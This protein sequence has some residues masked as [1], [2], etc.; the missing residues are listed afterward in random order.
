M[1]IYCKL[2]QMLYNCCFL[3]GIGKTTFIRVDMD[4]YRFWSSWSWGYI[5]GKNFCKILPLPYPLPKGWEIKGFWPGY[6][7]KLFSV[8]NGLVNT[9]EASVNKISLN[10]FWWLR[11]TKTRDDSHKKSVE[12]RNWNKEQRYDPILKNIYTWPLWLF[13]DWI[14]KKY[15]ANIMTPVNFWSPPSTET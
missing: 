6:L 11:L 8:D 4:S 3:N 12:I 7:P 15:L 5:K 9:I 2:R 1:A 10:I 13:I 14:K